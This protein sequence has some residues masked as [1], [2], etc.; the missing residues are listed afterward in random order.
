MISL[1]PGSAFADR[2]PH[3]FD[4]C[5]EVPELT[6]K[7]GPG[8][9]DACHLDPAARPRLRERATRLDLAGPEKTEEPA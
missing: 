3:R 5:G 2:C 9:L 4:R 8:H 6:G 7:A 1:P